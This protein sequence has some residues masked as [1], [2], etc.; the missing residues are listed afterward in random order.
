MS[1][2][3]GRVMRGVLD[4]LEAGPLSAPLLAQTVGASEGSTRRAL[5]ILQDRRAVVCL[6]F[7]MGSGQRWAL[8][9]TAAEDLAHLWTS[10]R[11]ARLTRVMGPRFTQWMRRA[12]VAAL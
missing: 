10:E 8:P 12:L 1:R 11:A 4:A 9:G 2:G 6:G 5:R 7:E 3:P